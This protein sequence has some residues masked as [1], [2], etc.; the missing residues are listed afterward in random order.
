MMTDLVPYVLTCL[1]SFHVLTPATARRFYA[2]RFWVIHIPS[3]LI[4]ASKSNSAVAVIVNFV[5]KFTDT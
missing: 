4:T 5:L 2:S 3:N 1:P